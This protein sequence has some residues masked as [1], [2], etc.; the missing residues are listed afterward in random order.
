MTVSVELDFEIVYTSMSIYH[1]SLALAD[2]WNEHD[3]DNATPKKLKSKNESKKT[4]RIFWVCVGCEL[5]TKIGTILRRFIAAEAWVWIRFLAQNHLG[6]A[7]YCWNLISSVRIFWFFSILYSWLMRREC[8]TTQIPN[9]NELEYDL[10][11]IQSECLINRSVG[12]FCFW[13][14]QHFRFEYSRCI[15]CCGGTETHL[16]VSVTSSCLL[17]VRACMVQ[18]VQ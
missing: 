3:C 9:D 8:H 1:I 12:Y 15:L 6:S 5:M 18:L 13:K 10:F 11:W 2:V 4:W 17:H 16:C 7:V 14:V